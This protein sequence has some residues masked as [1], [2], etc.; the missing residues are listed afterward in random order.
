MQ[1]KHFVKRFLAARHIQIR[2]QSNLLDFLNSRQIDVVLDVGANTGQFGQS[3]RDMGY[4]GRIISFEPILS[5]FQQLSARAAHDPRWE[6]RNCGL[7][8]K[9]EKKTINVTS[10]SVFSSMVPQTAFT[11]AFD[12]SAHVVR[13]EVVDVQ[14]LDSLFKGIGS[15]HVFLKIDTQG[16]ERAVLDGARD[17]L[18]HIL[19]LQLEL[20]VEHL[21]QDTW[22]FEEAIGYMRSKGFLPAQITPVKSTKDVV[23][24]A[25]EFDCVFRRAE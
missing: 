6:A 22:R 4:Q 21:Y 5:V 14:T 13:T 9:A 11:E 20:P 2:R 24:A 12:A 25:Y 15:G 16:Y 1:I 10:N 7:G 17:S 18:P 3:L 8:D 23:P 19:G